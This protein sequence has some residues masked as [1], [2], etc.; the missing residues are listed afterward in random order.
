MKAIVCDESIV[1]FLRSADPKLQRV[2]DEVDREAFE[3]SDKSPYCALVGAVIGQKIRFAKARELRGKIYR[4]LGGT[5]FGPQHTKKLSNAEL[6]RLGL[7]VRQ[8]EI[9]RRVECWCLE[10][11]AWSTNE[12][13]EQMRCNVRGVGPW[14]IQVI[15]LSALTD[16]DVFPTNDVFVNQRIKKLYGLPTRP[17]KRKVL[18]IAAK[19]SPYRSVVCWWLW[20]WF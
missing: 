18:E 13:L 5:L 8:I 20:R 19:W 1:S 10:H 14:T 4:K 12:G 16:L 9:L 6:G 3:I 2:F 7:E 11:P 15:K 17:T